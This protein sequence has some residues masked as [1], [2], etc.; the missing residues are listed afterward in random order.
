M[1]R[2]ARPAAT[3]HRDGEDG[4]AQD[5]Q[6]PPGA[7]Y[8]CGAPAGPAAGDEATMAAIAEVLTLT[9]LAPAVAGHLAGLRPVGLDP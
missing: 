6:L 9:C 1:V 4:Q 2:A 8:M 3:P 5:Q 7:A